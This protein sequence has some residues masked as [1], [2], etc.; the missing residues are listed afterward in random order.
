MINPSFEE[1]EKI[2]ISRYA[3]VVMASKRSRRIVDGSKPLIQTKNK[4]PV[5][6]AIE[7]IMEGK[8]VEAEEK[9]SK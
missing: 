9:A 4:K 7:E 3:I 5:S 2:H 8:V 1:L 6:I